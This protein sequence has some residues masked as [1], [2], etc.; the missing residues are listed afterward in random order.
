MADGSHDRVLAPAGWGWH[1]GAVMAGDALDMLPELPLLKHVNGSR[2]L[3]LAKAV[4][5]VPG[6]LAIVRPIDLQKKYGVPQSTASESL[7]LARSHRN[8]EAL[9]G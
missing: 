2:Q 4:T 9:R 5:S 1:P 8:L 7:R 3:V 6:L